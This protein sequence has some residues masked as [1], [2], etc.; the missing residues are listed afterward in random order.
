LNRD[1]G[2][3]KT[4]LVLEKI[5]AF[6]DVPILHN[7]MSN[8][9]QAEPFCSDPVQRAEFSLLNK[10]GV[11]VSESI[12]MGKGA[13]ITEI[14]REEWELVL[15]GVAQHL[16]PRL[17]FMSKDHRLVH[18]FVVKELS[19]AGEPLSPEFIARELNM[20][21]DL[22]NLILEEL[23]EHLIFLFRNDRGEVVWAYPVTVDD[24]PHSI[25]LSTGQQLYAA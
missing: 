15:S 13:Q 19:N 5:I 2:A 9:K 24:T 20:S 17:G 6:Q 11:F 25:T 10:G 4:V 8:H 16:E 22:V 14:P 23:E 3:Y 7:S 1:D 21:G 18:H 12:L